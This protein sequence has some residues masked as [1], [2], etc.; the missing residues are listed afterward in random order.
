MYI[1]ENIT[2]IITWYLSTYIQPLR[3]PDSFIFQLFQF[4]KTQFKKKQNQENLL[5]Y[6][7]IQLAILQLNYTILSVSKAN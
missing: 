5:H 6:Y 7:L 4:Y 3:F 1:C 2:I